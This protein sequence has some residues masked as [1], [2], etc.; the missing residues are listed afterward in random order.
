MRFV[1]NILDIGGF[2][3][4]ILIEDKFKVV[5]VYYGFDFEIFY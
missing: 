3:V 5:D 2:D 4:N 1:I